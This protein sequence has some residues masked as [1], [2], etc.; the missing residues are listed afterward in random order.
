M[1][2]NQPKSNK[3]DAEI[4][5]RPLKRPGWGLIQDVRTV[6]SSRSTAPRP[7]V[8]QPEARP[9]PFVKADSEVRLAPKVQK[10]SRHHRF[11]QWSKKH[12]MWLCS[13]FV[14][15]ASVGLSYIPLVG[16]GIIVAYGVLAVVKRTPS[17]VSFWL[18]TVILTGVGVE[19]LVLPGVGQ[20]NNNALFVFLFLVIGLLSSALETRRLTA[21]NRASRRR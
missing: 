1:T 12:Y 6:R 10:N 5:S 13:P 17:S 15:A 14:F 19:F 4:N 18:A 9:S 8:T 21:R 16:E 2:D 11:L 20:A 7:A 3:Q